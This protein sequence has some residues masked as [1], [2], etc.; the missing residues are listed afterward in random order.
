[1]NHPSVFL[2]PFLFC[3]S[4]QNAI[5]HNNIKSLSMGLARNENCID[6]TETLPTTKTFFMPD[7]AFRDIILPSHSATSRALFMHSTFR[8]KKGEGLLAEKWIH[9]VSCHSDNKFDQFMWEFQQ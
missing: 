5:M 9:F 1:M 4:S 2:L 3:F 7:V 6:K 8:D